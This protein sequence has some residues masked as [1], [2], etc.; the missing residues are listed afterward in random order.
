VDE[1]GEW[2]NAQHTDRNGTNR[3][4]VRQQKHSKIGTLHAKFTRIG[5]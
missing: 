4:T 3:M 5:R 1:Q 2:L